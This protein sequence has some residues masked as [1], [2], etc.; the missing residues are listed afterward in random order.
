MKNLLVIELC[1]LYVRVE[2]CFEF[3]IAYTYI[4]IICIYISKKKIFRAFY[5]ARGY[6][7]YHVNRGYYCFYNQADILGSLRTLDHGKQSIKP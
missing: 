3:K 4:Y 6:S 1:L 7:R 2:T 5:R